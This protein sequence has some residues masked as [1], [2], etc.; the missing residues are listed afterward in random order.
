MCF[1]CLRKQEPSRLQHVA[2]MPEGR[3]VSS[4]HGTPARSLL[5]H[6][7]RN[8]GEVPRHVQKPQWIHSVPVVLGLNG[9][10]FHYHADR[11]QLVVRKVADKREVKRLHA[12]RKLLRG[13]AR[14]V[15]MDREFVRRRTRGVRVDRPSQPSHPVAKVIP[16]RVGDAGRDRLPARIAQ[17][18]G[19]P[20]PQ[21]L[22]PQRVELLSEPLDF[23]GKSSVLGNR[24]RVGPPP[25]P[26]RDCHAESV[27]SHSQ[28]RRPGGAHRQECAIGHVRVALC[29]IPHDVVVRCRVPGVHPLACPRH[30]VAH[31][32][33]SST[34]SMID[35]M[36]FHGSSNSES[37]NAT[38]A[39]SRP[40]I[41]TLSSLWSI[42]SE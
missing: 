5:R 36:N 16:D 22:A 9:H 4:P 14:S 8:A 42:K 25:D 17:R 10:G 13:Q 41:R 18:L 30:T 34:G 15:D 12:C 23:M 29:N 24:R 6:R 21:S 1:T 20:Q 27:L 26:P 38:A 33:N 3:I 31:H 11:M 28:G 32:W 40:L 2:K 19:K 39:A 37:L 35:L 7:L